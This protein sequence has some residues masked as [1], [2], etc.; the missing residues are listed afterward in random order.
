MNTSNP[1][2]PA[3][4][5]V[6]YDP[7]AQGAG[8]ARAVPSTE[9]QRELWLACQLG[10]QASLAYNESISLRL[11]GRVDETAVHDAIE[12]LVRRHDALR[13]TF[14]TDGQDMLV[15]ESVELSMPVQDL[16]ALDPAQ[17]DVSVRRHIRADVD[18]PFDLSR[19]P[20]FRV[21]LLECEADEVLLVFTAHHIVCDGWSFGVLLN[22]LAALLEGRKLADAHSFAAYAQA[23]RDEPAVQTRE[24]DEKYWL[25]AYR[26]LPAALE[27]P[28]DRPRTAQRA[29]A[30][31]REDLAVDA[32]TVDALRG[33]A[34][35]YGVSLFALL[36]GSF[37]G[38]LA[39]LAGQRDLVV[40]ISAA[41]QAAQGLSD[42][43]GHCVHLLPVRVDIDADAAMGQVAAASSTALL[44]ALEH[45]SISFGSLLQRLQVPRDPGR[46]PLVP[47]IF[48]LDSRIDPEIF[49]KSGLR[50][51][52]ES[53]P[54]SAENFELY[55]N[56][57]P[58]AQGMLL[59]CQYKTDLFE[60][61]TVQRWLRLYAAAL[62]RI[63]EQP[64]LALAQA[65]APT[66]AELEQLERW[67]S[68]SR[69][70][71]QEL[72][73]GDLLM[74]GIS[75]DR[76]ADALVFEG[77]RLSYGELETRAWAVAEALR[78]AGIGPGQAV[79]VC[80]PRSIELVLALLASVL[81]GGAYVPLD[82][83]L[84][85][86]RLADMTQDAGLRVLLTSRAEH[87]RLGAAFGDQVR[88]L[89][90]EELQAAGA[91]DVALRGQPED[92]VYILFTSGSTG[93]P[94][95]AMNAH[96][97]VV[98][99][100]LWMQERFRLQPGERVLQ[101]TPFSFDVSVWEFFWPLSV[102]ATLVIAR[103]DGHR[104]SAYLAAL[105]R[106]ERVDVMHFVPS[107]LQ[108]F[109]DE[110]AAAECTRLRQVV[111][112]GE[113]L[114]RERVEQFF[115]M[116]PR[117]GLANLYGPTEA[118]VDVSCWEC[119]PDATM[120]RVPIGM[121]IAN[122]RLHV[123]DSKLRLLPIG[124]VGELYIGGVQVGLGYVGNEELTRQRFL[125]D[126]AHSGGRLYRTG[127]L[128]RWRGDGALEYLGR[129]DDQVKVR[130]YRIE[131]G[132]IEARLLKLSGVRSAVAMVR[133]DTPGDRR[134]VAY[135]AGAA[136]AD[137]P[138]ALREALRDQ[139]PEFML[140]QA[141]V[142]LKDLPLLSSGKVNRRALPAPARPRA[143]PSQ[144]VAPR[145]PTEA[146]VL[147][148][149][150]AVLKLPGL[151]VHDDFFAM[152]GHSLLAARLVARLNGELGLNLPLHDVFEAPT[153]EALARIVDK[154]QAEGVER[155]VLQHDAQRRTAPLTA[156]Q[157]RV[158]FMQELHPERVTYNAPSAHRLEGSLRPDDLVQALRRVVQ[159]QSI[160]RTSIRGESGAYE[161][162]VHDE[163]EFDVPT[164]DLGALPPERREQDL[165]QRMQAIVDRPMD[166]RVA[167]LF[168]SALFRLEPDV[169][170][171]LFMPHHI[172]WD[173]WSFDLLYEEMS[174]CLDAVVNLHPVRL[175]EPKVSY[176]D[177][178]CWQ[179]EWMD[180]AVYERLLEQ[181]T[182]R[183][184]SSVSTARPLA[185][186]M[187]R[188]AGMTGAGASEWVRIDA[189]TT[190]RLREVARAA[191]VTLN[192]L[193]LG[194]FAAMLSRVFDVPGLT[195][196]VPVRGRLVP[197]LE[198]VM[199][200]FNNLL[201]LPLQVDRGRSVSGYL[202]A[203]K[204]ELVETLRFQE[205]P[206]ERLAS[207]PSLRNQGG[208]A[209]LYQALFS[210][211]DARERDRHWAGLR[212]SN[213][214]I[215][216]GAAT[217]DLGL[218]LMDVPSGLEGGFN[219]NAEIYKAA[220][221]RA[222]R[223]LYLQVIARVAVQ[224]EASISELFDLGTFASAADLVHLAK[225]TT[226][227]EAADQGAP[228]RRALGQTE[229]D[230]AR[231]WAE[232]LGMKVERIGPDDN[233]FDIGGDSLAAMEVIARLQ[234]DTGKRANPRLLIFENLAQF[235]AS[236]DELPAAPA[237]PAPGLL[238]RLLGRGR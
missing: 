11:H 66:D 126:P 178:A 205:I 78:E 222:L 42:L 128:A 213:V 100:L 9:A 89:F 116:F 159:R 154:A 202:G 43:V 98:N 109:L 203:V 219:Y 182:T 20:L 195:V 48:N 83:I 23:E 134:I 4:E 25:D 32:A 155:I 88:P 170:V 125:D 30:S 65:F 58:G 115:R 208:H 49:A 121:P 93:R 191:D 72:R 211:Q 218:W 81:S 33:V 177:Y 172:I 120:R 101:K 179:H 161:Q 189:S 60:R 229:Q 24:V 67:N 196:G 232:L 183:L 111:C 230:L 190:D 95:G 104:D 10:A 148:A 85:A 56:V 173:G 140:P 143:S 70:Y 16:S 38:L 77:A 132:E 123:M 106:Q 174:A 41:A 27:L 160:L 127:D 68:T 19:G 186:D 31:L 8:F 5:A 175:A 136:L 129:G 147:A 212:Q 108:F 156:Q 236:L 80:L 204:H 152:G 71:A 59:E 194:V 234:R 139:L 209:G 220:T 45:Q 36:F 94:K 103:P 51:R 192:M 223:D 135:A 201:P 52:V 79:G 163:V 40:G 107:M 216:Q 63:C 217:E 200:F 74:Q 110:P 150:E 76:S 17:R 13:A 118:A 39:R 113:A 12:Q 21:R 233:F 86:S 198:N 3:L 54:R 168:R 146:R 162:V 1:A 130:G 199:G 2:Q 97:G 57:T 169:H 231:I 114:D 185:T 142:C 164:I 35:G 184:A 55:L 224:P 69:P 75:R 227:P 46:L 158:A 82:P 181:W 50:A 22:D 124:A 151:G 225:A 18:E 61:E 29:F 167:P 226:A 153:A 15:A 28:V 117:T 228:Q 7:F 210:F 237:A 131:L 53:N 112:S 176:A 87:A 207:E 105:V 221:V 133:E 188:G 215:L 149:M 166:L 122:T 102:G 44:D 99:R 90:I 171:F 73:L 34:S 96:R 206:F 238:R 91:A 119:R 62:R 144:V 47:V 197:E 180:S 214:L 92:P 235:A 141:V 64:G 138:A 6:D 14:S 165:M 26:E 145:N 137:D 37:A 84:P 187:P 193:T 157:E